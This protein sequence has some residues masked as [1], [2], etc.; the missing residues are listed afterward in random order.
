MTA[1]CFNCIHCQGNPERTVERSVEHWCGCSEQLRTCYV[2]GS[3]YRP[4]CH[5]VNTDG[6]C[7]SFTTRRVTGQLKTRTGAVRDFSY[8]SVGDIAANRHAIETQYMPGSKV[9]TMRIQ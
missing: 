4:H 8:A 3:R 2:D 9:L 7:S 5:H 6:K 1:I